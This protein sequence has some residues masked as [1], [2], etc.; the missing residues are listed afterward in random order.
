MNLLAEARRGSRPFSNK[1]LPNVQLL[2][3]F[4]PCWL[5]YMP[6]S[7][8]GMQQYAPWKRGRIG[9]EKESRAGGDVGL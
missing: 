6:D 9:A 7:V 3:F 4:F 8:F 1:F 5:G 2:I